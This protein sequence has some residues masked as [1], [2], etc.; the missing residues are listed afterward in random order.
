MDLA[1]FGSQFGEK[2]HLVKITE[3]VSEKFKT[4]FD[5]DLTNLIPYLLIFGSTRSDEPGS[6]N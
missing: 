1:I 5:Y 3:N 2:M 4:C 6:G